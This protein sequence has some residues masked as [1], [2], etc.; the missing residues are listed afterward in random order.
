[1]KRSWVLGSV[2]ILAVIAFT[3]FGWI[4]WRKKDPLEVCA[5][6]EPMPG[7]QDVCVFP[8]NPG[9]WNT[10][11]VVP[12]EI[13]IDVAKHERVR[14]KIG[15]DPGGAKVRVKFKDDHPLVAPDEI[16]INVSASQPYSDPAAAA[17]PADPNKKYEYEIYHIG[18]TPQNRCADPK[19]ILK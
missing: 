6:I 1:M 13:A 15:A 17:L 8:V 12:E 18:V 14:W 19:L 10:C 2:G 16:L 7:V 3:I 5:S 11:K 4:F 9:D